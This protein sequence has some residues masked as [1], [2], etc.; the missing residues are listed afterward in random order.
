MCF[1]ILFLLFITKEIE[2]ASQLTDKLK[3]SHLMSLFVLIC[4]VDFL[5][6]I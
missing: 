5:S 6:E 3:V 4:L 1:S 2:N